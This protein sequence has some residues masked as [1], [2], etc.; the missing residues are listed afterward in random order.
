MEDP[1]RTALAE[2]HV[3]VIVGMIDDGLHEKSGYHKWMIVYNLWARRQGFLW[4]IVREA[5]G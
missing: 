5:V 1:R 2:G 4:L 3:E